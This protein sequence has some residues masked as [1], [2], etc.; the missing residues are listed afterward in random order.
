MCYLS[1]GPSKHQVSP[2]DARKNL[3]DGNRRFVLEKLASKDVG[4][5]RRIQL[6]EEGQFPFAVI[7][8]CSD[9]R[10]SPEILF[11][12][13]LGDIFVIRTA[14]NVLD[15]VAMGSVEYAVDHLNCSLVVV[16]GHENCGAVKA[17][18][19]G[20]TP[21][22]SIGAITDIIAPSVEK[23]LKKGLTGTELCEEAAKE[24]VFAVLAHLGT[25]PVVKHLIEEGKLTLL[26]AKYLLGSGEVEFYG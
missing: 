25:S 9:S 14:G 16:L 24:N 5:K 22:G 15:K 12:Q 10:V 18:V 11:D 23:V 6:L 8:T 26:G 1:H 20:G 4:A 21:P 17:T 19:E 2:A 13:A 7:V 3:V